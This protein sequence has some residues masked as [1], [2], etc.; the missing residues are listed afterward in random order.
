MGV[1]PNLN[2]FLEHYWHIIGSK[3]WEHKVPEFSKEEYC[4]ISRDPSPSASKDNSAFSSVV[5]RDVWAVD[6]KI[7]M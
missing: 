4:S 2:N 1:A 3:N 6:D 7:G 5:E